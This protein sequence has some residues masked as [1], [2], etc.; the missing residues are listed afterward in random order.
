MAIAMA[1]N[2]GSLATITG[3][4]QNMII[5]SLS[6]ITYAHF[7]AALAPIAAIGLVL[8]VVAIML[9]YPSEFRRHRPF[10]A[11]FAPVRANRP[12]LIKSV[13]VLLAIIASFFMGLN[14]SAYCRQGSLRD[15][16]SCPMPSNVFLRYT[17]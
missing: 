8:T 17:L 12:L 1:S 10:R 13:A 14:P 9:A 11:T 3:N 16:Q 4:P 5:A 6:R 7:S 15:L 2:I